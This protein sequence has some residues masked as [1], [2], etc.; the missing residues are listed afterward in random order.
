MLNDTESPVAA[1]YALRG[2]VGVCSSLSILG[3][4]AIIL[5][6]AAFEELRTTARQLLLN[7]SIA[8]IINSLFLLFGLFLNAGMLNLREKR[9]LEPIN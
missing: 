1:L 9:S 2:A 3:S 6:Y 8:D 7:L 5:S 4:C